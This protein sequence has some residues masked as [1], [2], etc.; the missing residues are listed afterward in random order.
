M[1]KRISNAFLLLR[2][3]RDTAAPVILFINGAV[4]DVMVSSYSRRS[5]VETIR[6]DDGTKNF[7]WVKKKAKYD[8]Y[9]CM[10]NKQA[11]QI[12]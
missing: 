11:H 5:F 3:T 2:N 9:L 1:G 4:H 12:T 7:S 10:T 8:K 6:F